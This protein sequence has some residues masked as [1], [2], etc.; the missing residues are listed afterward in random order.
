MN[1]DDTVRARGSVKSYDPEHRIDDAI[2]TELFELVRRTPSSF[3]LQHWRFVLV[4]DAELRSQLMAASWNQSH[5]GECSVDVVICGKLAAHEDAQRIWDEAGA[6][7]ASKMV[8]M[9]QGFYA[10]RAQMQR[11]EA[12]R[13]CSLAGMTLMLAAESK[14]LSTCPM[15][16]FDPKKVAE[17]LGIP[18]DHVPVMLVT[19][20]KGVAPARPSGRLPLSEIA[21]L[22]SFDGAPLG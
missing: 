22:D 1:F 12:I 13:S 11:D 6:E 19:L 20:G 14:G 5:V 8:P 16:G 4:R 10:E 21:H 7:V 9:I 3:N 18:D 17:I 2:L 15:I